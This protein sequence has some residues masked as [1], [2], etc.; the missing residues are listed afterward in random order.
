[1]IAEADKMNLIATGRR[2]QQLPLSRRWP[3][4]FWLGTIFCFF[5]FPVFLVDVGL[6]SLLETR[7]NLQKQEISR[8]LKSNL[9]QLVQFK[10]SR[11]YYHALLKKVFDIAREQPDPFKYLN[12]ALPHLKIRNPEI[13]KFIVWNSAGQTI[14][15]LTD[16]KGY[17]YIVKTLFEVFSE[18]AKDCLNNYPG[19]PENLPVVEKRLNL[20][21]SYL[22]TFLIPEKLNLP[23]FRGNLGEIIL[24]ASEP[25]KSHFWFQSCGKFMMMANINVE[26]TKSTEYLKKL[27]TGMNKRTGRQIKCGIAELLDDKGIFTGFAHKYQEELLVEIGKFQ[28]FSESQLETPHYMI[29]VRMLNSFI[30]AF[31]FIE[32]EGNLIDTRKLRRSILVSLALVIIVVSGSFI[33]FIFRRDHIISIRFKL[34]LLFIYAN[35]L[36][37]MILGFLG[38]EYLQQTRK[39]L[40][41]QAQEQVAALITDFDTRYETITTQCATRLNDCVARINKNLTTRSLTKVDLEEFAEQIQKTRP[42]DFVIADKEGKLVLMKQRGQP[43]STFFANMSRNLLNY[44]NLNT[45]TPQHLFQNKRNSPEDDDTSSAEKFLSSK[46]ILLHRFLQYIGKITLQQ[47]GPEGRLFYWS[48]LGDYGKRN[49]SNVVV[50][51]WNHDTMQDSYIRQNLNELNSNFGQFKFYAIIE[52]NGTTYP[53]HTKIDREIFN[54]FRQTFNFKTTSSE[55]IEISGKKYAAFGTIGK[56]LGKAAIV[57]LIPLEKITASVNEIKTRLI[58]F[59]LL[60]LSLTLGI[61]RLLSSQFMQ[62]VKELE[63]G[64]QAIGKQ[65]FRYRLPI[66]SADEFGHLSNVF[67]TAI[68]S[69]EDLEI[70]KVVQENLFPQKNLNHGGIEIFGRSVAMTRLGGDY[71]DFFP[72]DDER[73][74][75]LMGDVAGHG[76]PAALL[77]AMAKASVLLG[78]EKKTDPALMLAALHKVIH[79]TK[80]TKIKRM[81]TCQYFCINSNSGEYTASNAGHCFPAV[82]R[83]GGQEVELITLIG[84]PLGITRNPKYENTCLKL[85][86]GDI[87]LLYTDG[88]IESQNREGKEMGFDNFTRMLGETFDTNLETY[89]ERIFKAYTNWSPE[90]DDDITMVLIGFK[91]QEDRA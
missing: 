83:K 72:I 37:L 56:E 71:Y 77:M 15:A 81:M 39:L 33:F 59:A 82:I 53:E 7:R 47:M 42:Y 87:V 74:G 35:G 70:A 32:K 38:Y 86:P 75:V 24:A 31:S 46:T 51:L 68:E 69:L 84:T 25:D 29:S 62:P 54:L 27:I 3:I 89:Y 36:P 48:M 90:A 10:E 11:H 79:S 14:D 85:E 13:F 4:A 60:S 16:E 58:I 26:A 80:S 49:F 57:G 76:V 19:S 18:V 1:M 41:D 45:F 67:N 66:K 30:T 21:R 22:G 44:V 52:T 73:V 9:E 17:R 91:K 55:E 5:V 78:K 43:S 23:L 61:G 28:N 6:D 34:A 64:V 40:L 88:I 2:D 8:E 50:I 65:N 20:L 12:K 63:L